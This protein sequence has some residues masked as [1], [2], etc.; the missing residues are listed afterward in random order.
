MKGT[1]KM[2]VYAKFLIY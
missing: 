1:H 2:S